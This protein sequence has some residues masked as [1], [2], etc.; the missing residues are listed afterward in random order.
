MSTL[1]SG[2]WSGW[3]IGITVLGLLGLLWLLLDM[4]FSA[5]QDSESDEVIWDDNLSEGSARLPAWWFL[6]LLGGLVFT[7]FYLMLYPGLGNNPG[8]LQWNQY[9]QFERG[10]EHYREKTTVTHNRW[11][12]APLSELMADPSAMASARRL[13]NNNCAGCHGEDA[14]GQANMFPNLRD[15]DWQWGNSEQQ[16]LQTI[17]HGRVAAMISWKTILREQGTRQT[18][19]YVLSLSGQQQS[20]W[21]ADIAAGQKLYKAY[22]IACHGADGGGVQVLGAPN[23]TDD[24]WLYGGD[25]QTVYQTILNGRSGQMPSQKL[26]LQPSQIRILTAWLAGGIKISPPN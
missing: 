22:C 16:L 8:F 1:A 4:R 5:P 12:M 2:F 17:T 20:G 15:A 19:R 18:A 9:N 25:E 10:M 23:L 11:E 24:I 6:L 14:R 3:V 7:V 26:R 13:F 21:E